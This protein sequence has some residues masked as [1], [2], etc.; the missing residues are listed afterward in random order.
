MVDAEKLFNLKPRRDGYCAGVP[1]GCGEPIT[2][3][4]D[5][6]SE[7]EYRITG[8]CQGCQDEMEEYGEW[9]ESLADMDEENM[10]APF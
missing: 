10:E 1:L 8:L 4:R 9:I 3:F 6:I 2:L 7:E 5:Q